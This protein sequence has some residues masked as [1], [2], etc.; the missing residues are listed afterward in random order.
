MILF[1]DVLTGI[2]I[3][4][5]LLIAVGYLL[6]LR[7]AVDVVTL[8]RIVVYA[9]LPSFL[10]YNLAT[11]PV[12]LASLGTS[13]WFTV[14]QFFALLAIGWLAATAARLSPG[15]RTIV[16]LATAFPNSGN[17]GIPLVQLAFGVA[18]VPQ[19]AVMV[20]LHTTLLLI[21]GVPLLGR[22]EVG[23]RRL[24]REVFRT[25]LVPAVVLGLAIKASGITLP[26]PIGLPLK[27][28][29]SALTPMALI[30]LGAQLCAA[31]PLSAT[32]GLGLGLA[33]RLGA[34]PLLTFAAA[35]FLNL[36][37]ELVELLVVGACTPVGVLLSIVAAEFGVKETLS[38]TLVIAS[39]ALSPLFASAALILLRAG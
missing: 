4:M 12:P 23:F 11:A 34:A 1:F 10:V 6:R 15:V 18:V 5:V 8:N 13:A 31:R 19:Q 26:E 30:A 20:S 3:P 21:I 24:V 25:P 2:T 14:G 33:L 29:G 22:G 36:P 35:Y 16:A 27:I 9:V 38:T 39:T 32:R 37:R 7:V 17:F 28:C